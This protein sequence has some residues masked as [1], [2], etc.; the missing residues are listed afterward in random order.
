MCNN[1]KKLRHKHNMT[2]FDLTQKLGIYASTYN[3]KENSKS[4]F[5][6]SEIKKLQEIFNLTFDEIFPTSNSQNE[7]KV[8]TSA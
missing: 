5:T 1:L 2:Q 3:Y 4:E 8:I 6:A 7:D